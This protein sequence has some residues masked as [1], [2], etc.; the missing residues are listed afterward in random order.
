MKRLV[1]GALARAGGGDALAGD[2]ARLSRLFT[3]DRGERASGYMND[4]ALR[5]AYLGYF[6]PLN[7][8]KVALLVARLVD[9]G[10]MALKP[11][12][13]VLDL[14]AG[15]LSATIGLSLVQGSLGSSVAVDRGRSVLDEGAALLRSLSPDAKVRTVSGDLRTL[16]PRDLG[17]PF[18]IIFIANALNEMGDARRGQGGR[19]SIVER[20]LSLLDDD[21]VLIIVEPATR[22]HT[23]ALQL[24]RDELVDAHGPVVR[25]PCPSSV[26]R[27]PLNDTRGDWCFSDLPWNPP[28]AFVALEQRAGL[29]SPVLQT[30][31]LVVGR[32]L[33]AVLGARIIGG[34]MQD[35]VVERRYLCTPRGRATAIARN[36]FV[37]SLRTATRGMW[38]PVLDDVELERTEPDSRPPRRDRRRPTGRRPR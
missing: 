19:L 12:P 9:E 36:G 16:S 22:V 21:G 13:R 10:R 6:A 25:A 33:P 18:D 24:L 32:P 34:R 38:L 11:A 28:P 3:T 14:G 37:G 8:I 15:P 4:P 31:Y 29:R 17:G 2:V 5:R 20:A 35:G 7:A 23:R 27:C 1:D 30:S 26:R